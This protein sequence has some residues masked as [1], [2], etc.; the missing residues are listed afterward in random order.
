MDRKNWIRKKNRLK[1]KLR[2]SSHAHR[3]IIFRSNKHI[4]GQVLN[5]EN[6]QIVLS[7]SSN[8]NEFLKGKKTDQTNKM[9]ASKI[10]AKT[11]S[12]KMKTN[13]I[14]KVVFDRNGYIYHGRVKAFAESLRENGINF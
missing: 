14:N 13:K 5:V 6:G 10:V 9:E 11:L 1:N 4:Y 8:D 12:D 3:L 2:K 7:S